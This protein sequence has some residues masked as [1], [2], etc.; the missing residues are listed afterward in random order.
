M[1]VIFL[2]IDGVLQAYNS[3]N[4][5]RVDRDAL[6]D[7]LSR[8]FNIDYSIYHKYDV[9]ACYLDWDKDAVERIRRI[10]RETDSK[11][12][13]S[14]DWRCKEKPNKMRDF[15]TLWNLE[16]Y[17][18]GETEIINK[19]E[20]K[21]AIEYI[22]SLGDENY[23]WRAVEI[24]D[25]VY[26]HNEINNFVAIDDRDISTGLD[27]HF[28]KTKNLITDE[29]TDRCIEILNNP[30]YELHKKIYNEEILEKCLP[31]CV[32]NDLKNLKDGIKNNVKHIDCLLNEL[33]GSVNSAYVDGEISE[34]QC[35]YLYKKYIRMKIPFEA[36]KLSIEP[37][38]E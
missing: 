17:L 6:R 23:S 28:V 20:M 26:K 2:D 1:K 30:K 10:I 38:K 11:I 19:E 16:E 14:S 18:L 8:E 7:K 22:E 5:F 31:K 12:V 21:E 25:Y 24:L 4:R 29:E 9:A 32:E 13:I 36:C 15:L 3:G 37:R 33:Q 27:G 34:E 35:D